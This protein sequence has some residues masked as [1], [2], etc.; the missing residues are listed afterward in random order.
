MALSPLQN[1]GRL[2]AA[3]LLLTTAMSLS[4]P[5]V[6][7]TLAFRGLEERP[8]P[9]WSLTAAETDGS[10][11]AVPASSDSDQTP[12][13]PGHA[14]PLPSE[15]VA[16]GPAT[17]QLDVQP[18]KNR[19]LSSGP[20]GTDRPRRRGY[21]ELPPPPESDA[22]ESRALRPTPVSDHSHSL[23]APP[24]RIESAP[25]TPSEASPFPISGVLRELVAELSLLRQ[26]L[27]G[28]ASEARQSSERSPSAVNTAD[29]DEWQRLESL[30]ADVR[31]IAERQIDLEQVLRSQTARHA[32]Q[33][34]EQRRWLA[35]AAGGVAAPG[36][37][38]A[39]RSSGTIEFTPVPERS[40][41]WTARFLRA[42]PADVVRELSA[43]GRWNLVVS[44][45]VSGV[46]TLTLS[47]ASAE[48]ILH[49]VAAALDCVVMDDGALRLLLPRSR[50][51]DYRIAR[52][53]SVAKFIQ[54][55]WI[56]AADLLGCIQPLLTP[57]LGSVALTAAAAPE[58]AAGTPSLHQTALLVVD[59]PEVVEQVEA[60]VADIDTPP[61]QLELEVVLTTVRSLSRT[62]ESLVAALRARGL[63]QPASTGGDCAAPWEGCA[64]YRGS[65]EDLLSCLRELTDVHVEA[66]PTLRV[67]N[68]QQAHL[69]IGSQIGYRKRSPVLHRLT[70]AAEEIDFLPSVTALT[71]R[72]AIQG[73]ETVRLQV[74]PRVTHARFDPLTHLPRQE[75][76]EIETDVVVPWGETIILG[77]LV[78][79]QSEQAL[80]AAPIAPW[81]RRL[82]RRAD[83]SLGDAETTEVLIL[84]TP[85]RATPN[86]P[87]TEL[88]RLS[89][90][91][92]LPPAEIERNPSG[93]SAAGR[94][95]QGRSQAWSLPPQQTPPTSSA[96]RTV[97]AQD[98]STRPDNTL[99]GPALSLPERSVWIP[100]PPSR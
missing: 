77:G 14:L 65:P 50:A 76:A 31:R 86:E 72:A 84:L 29:R 33:G 41:R 73:N 71:V 45:E 8:A 25:P 34:E 21:E 68:R 87:A 98:A 39:A 3:A 28:L 20:G 52:E 15:L 64:C 36:D 56:E 55:R 17:G 99:A 1:A 63:C 81:W 94:P 7:R 27:Q 4:V 100:P 70:P 83:A 78:R 37:L 75:T 46:V 12:S 6:R 95:S 38:P 91:P 85:R 62:E 26:D 57:G 97:L 93:L 5:G 79:R 23:D 74:H 53:R 9:D 43:L 89:P 60:L 54:P 80:S 18:V 10:G 42:E 44:P 66:T 69:E 16:D 47:D 35:E 51:S 32:S 59:F 24:D 13:P 88:A 22:S 90:P 82:G 61:E 2:L 58:G 67:L 40:D 96:S 19:G 49:G 92:R 48:E 30:H 11:P